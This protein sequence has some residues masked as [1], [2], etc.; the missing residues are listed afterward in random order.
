MKIRD[1]QNLRNRM[2]VGSGRQRTR[3]RPRLATAMGPRPRGSR[4][5]ADNPPPPWVKVVRRPVWQGYDPPPHRDVRR[6]V[7]RFET[8]EKTAASLTNR[9]ARLLSA[10]R[11]ASGRADEMSRLRPR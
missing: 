9:C 6:L 7:A 5:A 2:R 1:R 8:V 10:N 4:D 3:S 11:H